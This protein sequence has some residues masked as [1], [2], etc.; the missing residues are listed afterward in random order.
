MFP[1]AWSESQI[2]NRRSNA[3]QNAASSESYQVRDHT[4]GGGNCLPN[5][6]KRN[7]CEGC[8]DHPDSPS[9][10]GDHRYH[11]GPPNWQEDDCADEANERD[12]DCKRRE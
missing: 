9:D 5:A 3:A 12:A 2:D 6:H 10:G 4:A 7:R 1:L 11:S 8:N